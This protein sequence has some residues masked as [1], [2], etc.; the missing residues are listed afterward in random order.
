MS[1]EIFN[2]K[3]CDRELTFEECKY[4]GNYYEGKKVWCEKCFNELK[5]YL[6]KKYLEEKIPELRQQANKLLEEC[7]KNKKEFVNIIKQ[8]KRF[9]TGL[10]KE[11]NVEGIQNFSEQYELNDFLKE[12]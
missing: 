10:E 4:F 8:I 5:E 1:E 6:H 7:E 9:I 11:N 12:K 3:K 2:C